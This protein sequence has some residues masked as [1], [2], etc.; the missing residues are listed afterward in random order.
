MMM[1]AMIAESKP[2]LE[3][4]VELEAIQGNI[5]PG[6]AYI[7]TGIYMDLQ[8][9]PF[10]DAYFTFSL[11]DTEM[12]YSRL[13]GTFNSVLRCEIWK[14]SILHVL[15]YAVEVNGGGGGLI[16]LDTPIDMHISIAE[17]WIDMN[18]YKSYL[19]DVDNLQEQSLLLLYALNGDRGSIALCHGGHAYIGGVLARDFIPLI[20]TSDVPA[21]MSY[22]DK[23]HYAGECGL[24]DKVAN[25]FFGNAGTG[26]FIAHYKN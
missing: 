13:C 6:V 8:N 26:E 1:G 21:S 18:G 14:Y 3:Y 20:L 22:L 24:W 4:G 23:A 17:K 10:V 15:G 5:M 9:E 19:A 16:A 11:K 2:W 12:D 25:T 7:D